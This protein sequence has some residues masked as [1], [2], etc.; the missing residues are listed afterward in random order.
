MEMVSCQSEGLSAKSSPYQ[1]AYQN[2]GPVHRLAPHTHR[3]DLQVES[4]PEAVEYLLLHLRVES[5]RVQ[6]E[7]VH[8]EQDAPDLAQLERTLNRVH[9]RTELSQHGYN[10][11]DWEALHR[12]DAALDLLN[13]LPH[14]GVAD[15][16]PAGCIHSLERLAIRTQVI[17]THLDTSRLKSEDLTKKIVHC[18]PKFQNFALEVD[19][20]EPTRWRVR[21]KKLCILP[22]CAGVKALLEGLVVDGGTVEGHGG[23]LHPPHALHFVHPRED[24]AVDAL[25]GAPGPVR[26][27]EPLG[28]RPAVWLLQHC[29]LKDDHLRRVGMGDIH[30]S[31]LLGVLGTSL[32]SPS[33]VYEAANLLSLGV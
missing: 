28:L 31:C 10:L 19:L 6:Q 30:Y 27:E 16:D 20:S 9:F 24:E 15:G 11:V 3:L 32:V 33:N 17:F 5:L 22:T 2:L 7:A 21:F 23:C 13:P 8:I 26:Y 14:H 4:L 29:V 25:E 18:I 1:N 12:E